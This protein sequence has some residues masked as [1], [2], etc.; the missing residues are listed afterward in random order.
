MRDGDLFTNGDHLLA[1]L[2]DLVSVVTGNEARTPRPGD[3]SQSD[4][5][6]TAADTMRELMGETP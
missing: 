3:E 6:R 2:F 5:E 1:N 4:T